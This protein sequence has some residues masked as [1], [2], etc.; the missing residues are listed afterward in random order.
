MDQP[1]FNIT[2]SVDITPFLAYVKAR[3][4]AFTP[5]V[6]YCIART[7]NA[8]PV[9]RQRI[10]GDIVVEH[11][12]VH[13]NFTMLTEASDVFS[14]CNVSYEP[15]FAT[16]V[17]STL[18][19]MERMKHEPCLENEQGRDDYLYLSSFP[20][21]SF[22]SMAHAMHYSPPDSMPRVVW[23][24]YVK[25]RDRVSMPLSVQAHHALVDGRHTGQFFELIQEL[26]LRPESLETA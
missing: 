1:H 12:R 13:P 22:T 8:I 23:G 10:R 3:Q 24:K 25:D 17:A 2:A 21:V 26:F 19:H 14:F 6:V 18:A 9:F 16:F 15:R 5:A 4:I 11:D 7:G 20:W